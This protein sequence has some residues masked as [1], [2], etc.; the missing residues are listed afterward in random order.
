MKR[1]IAL[2]LTLFF[3]TLLVGCSENQTEQELTKISLR[4]PIPVVD[5]GLSPFYLA[6]DKGYYEEQGLDVTLKLGSAEAN[7]LKMVIAGEDEF[8][9]VGGPDLII[10]GRNKQLSIKAIAIMH[11]DSDLPIIIT[12]KES[13]IDTVEELEGK[14]I[15]MFYGHSSTNIIRSLLHQEGISVEEVNVGFDYSQFIA[16]KIDAEWAFRT[17]AGV[18][19]PEKGIEINIISPAD[20]GIT[21]HGLTIFTTEEMIEENPELVQKF[22]SATIKGIEHTL[23]NPEDGIE[24]TIQRNKK[25]DPEVEMK[26]LLIDNL[27]T[28]PNGEMNKEM[29]QETY[30][31]MLESE[32]V[33]EGLNVEEMFTTQFIQ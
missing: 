32:L 1:T 25:L 33:K 7:P 21:T 9:V 5:V 4:L 19:L 3:I 10:T 20:Y 15:G 29:F 24:S 13:G 2:I 31:R 26:R 6:V 14:K 17:T 11:K 18:T 22:V 8:G 27:V 23:T 30:D 16:G 28:S 12:K